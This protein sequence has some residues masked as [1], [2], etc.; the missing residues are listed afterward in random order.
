MILRSLYLQHFRSYTNKKLDFSDEFSVVIGP[1]TAGKTNLSEAI[2]LLLTGKSFRTSRDTDMIAFDEAITRVGGMLSENNVVASE[3]EATF[4]DGIAASVA[5]GEPP[6]NDTVKMEVVI[7]SPQAT[8]GRLSKKFLINGVTKAKSAFVGLLPIV[9]F[10]PE[11][12]EIIIDGP[13]LRR[14]FLNSVLEQTD[15]EYAVAKHTYE[16]SLRQ[17]NALLRIAQ[18]TPFRQGYKG[19]AGRAHAEQFA[20][21]DDLLIENGQILTKKREDFLNFVNEFEQTIFSLTTTYD[22]STISR[23]RLDMYKDAEIGAGV[24]LVGPHRDDFFVSMNVG[25]KQKDMRDFGSRGQQRLAVLQLKMLQIAYILEKTGKKPLLV[26]DDIF[27]ELDA[28]HIQ[29]V[30]DNVRESQG[31]LTTTHKE[32]VPKKIL[33]KA[34]V[35]ELEK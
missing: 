2:H 14:D 33:D 29:L 22:K 13:S 35:I 17:R 15:R 21:W 32:F 5:K 4:P 34:T 9:L 7:A 24:T 19:Q 30:L 28:H 11:E 6:R 10:R 31:I 26:L 20:Y 25:G 1:N 16:R 27:S 18:E 12:L 8:G 3:S 23:E